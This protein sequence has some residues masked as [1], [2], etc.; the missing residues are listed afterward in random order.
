VNGDAGLS[1]REL[2]C[3]RGERMVFEGL[4]FD[5]A[6]G[7]A[8][9][10][11]GPNGS[12][13]TSFLRLVAGLLRPAAGSLAWRGR[14]V[15]DDPDA[16]RAELHYVGHLDAVKP[17]LTV[18]EN[19][20]FWAR[21]R[22]GGAVT[23]ALAGFGLTALANVPAR[24]LSAGQRR[25]VA[26]A[27]LLAAPAALWLLDE[28]TVG[29]DSESIEALTSAM[30]AQRDSGGMVIAATHATLSLRD[31]GALQFGAA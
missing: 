18:S 10:L 13:K 22:G 16:L 26:L 28:P 19:L 24:F 11:T 30:A 20:V 1:G 25:R 14:P 2:A 9:V 21:M 4:G 27:R 3:L 15:G 12:G 6:P 5:L 8:L 17:L 29:L 7:G 31:A 23:E